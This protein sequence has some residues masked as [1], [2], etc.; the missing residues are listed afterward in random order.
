MNQT[1]Q[2]SSQ[3]SL[4]SDKIFWH[5]YIPFYETFFAGRTFLRIAKFGVYKGRSIRW[6][7]EYFQDA[8]VYGADILPIQAEWPVDARFHFTQLDR[9]S[10]E[11]IHQF[12]N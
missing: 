7:L 10:R 3:E 8:T 6:L 9:E 5:G 11:Q 2:K 1:T 4:L 12:L